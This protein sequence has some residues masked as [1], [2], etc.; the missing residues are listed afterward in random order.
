MLSLWKPFTTNGFWSLD[1]A[2]DGMIRDIERPAV[3]SVPAVEIFEDD[4]A[5]TVKV[6][7][8]GLDA[9][10]IKI[11]VENDVLQLRAERKQETEEK[12]RIWHRSEISYGAFARSFTLPSAIDGGKTDA[13]YENGV[14]TLVLPKR[15]E[16]K[17]KS[18]TVQVKG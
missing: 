3:E 17:P 10:E 4:N 13:K 15:E 6:D 16:A 12:G 8:P 7:L 14:L 2:L 18:V 1:R 5:Y 11:T 9:K